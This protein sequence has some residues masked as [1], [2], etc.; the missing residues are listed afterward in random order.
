[1]IRIIS[2]VSRD[3]LSSFHELLSE[4]TVGRLRPSCAVWHGAA[5][6]IQESGGIGRG[7]GSTSWCC[8]REA[9]ATIRRASRSRS[10]YSG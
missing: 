1:M 2:V 4:A 10:I 7:G 6:D 3:N 9:A 5:V 8:C